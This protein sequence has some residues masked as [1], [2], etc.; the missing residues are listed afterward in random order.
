MK[1]AKKNFWRPQQKTRLKKMIFYDFFALIWSNGLENSG[2]AFGLTFKAIKTKKATQ[3]PNIRKS[4]IWKRRTQIL[5][6]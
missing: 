6:P 4:H 2:N 3:R 1:K 5:L